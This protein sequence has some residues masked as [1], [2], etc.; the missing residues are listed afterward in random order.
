MLFNALLYPQTLFYPLRLLKTQNYIKTYFILELLET[1]ERVIH[2]FPQLLPKIQF[3]NLIEGLNLEKKLLE[4]FKKEIYNLAYEIKDLENLRIFQLHQKLF[5]ETF[6]LSAIKTMPENPIVVSTIRLILAEDIDT[7][8]LEVS[9]ALNKFSQDWEK[10]LKEKILYEEEIFEEIKEGE[11]QGKE[12]LWDQ[13]KRILALKLIFSKMSWGI[14]CKEIDTLL[15]SEEKILDD[16]FDGLALE[17]KENLSQDL[18]LY[19]FKEQLNERIGISKACDLPAL[20][21]VLFVKP[22]VKSS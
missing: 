21:Q 13:E 3:I 7:N 9:L 22:S 8:L 17:S 4:N 20:K 6:N 18:E 10:L 1:K 5:E 19:I 2:F 14:E 16:L 12:E 11:N 15:I